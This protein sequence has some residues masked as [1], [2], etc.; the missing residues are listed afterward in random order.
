LLGVFEQVL[1]ADDPFVEPSTRT[2]I[3]SMNDPIPASASAASG[4]AKSQ[5]RESAGS[6]MNPSKLVAV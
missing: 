6:A 4:T 2:P 1:V 3:R 5:S